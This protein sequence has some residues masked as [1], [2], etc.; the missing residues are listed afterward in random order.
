MVIK[1]GDT[2]K[3]DNDIENSIGRV[4]PFMVTLVF[5]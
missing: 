1:D 3:Y 2:F 5:I 4:K